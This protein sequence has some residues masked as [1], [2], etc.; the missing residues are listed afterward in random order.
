MSEFEVLE[1]A[2]VSLAVLKEK[3]QAMKGEGEL[4]F[5]AEKTSSYLE[6][7]PIASVKEAE[8]LSQKIMELNIP[9]LKDRH[10][11]KIVDIMP[12]DLDSLRLLLTTETLTVKDE[13]LKKI[14]DVIPQ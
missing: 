4:P 12:K 5:R 6:G 9:R 14:L 11:V 7:F 2:P 8:S 3:L 13:D 1:E 10:I